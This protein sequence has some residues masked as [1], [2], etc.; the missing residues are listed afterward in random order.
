MPIA[1]C[2]VKKES[3]QF[4]KCLGSFFGHFATLK[5]YKVKF[6]TDTSCVGMTARK[7]TKILQSFGL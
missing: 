6:F 5:F 3:L 7:V 1:Y 2:S 4:D